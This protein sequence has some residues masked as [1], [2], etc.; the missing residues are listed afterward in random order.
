MHVDIDAFRRQFEKQHIG[1]V[2]F[3]MQHVAIGLADG[4][5]E[6]FVAHEAAVDKQILRVAPGARIRRQAGQTEQAQRAGCLVQRAGG[7]GEILAEHFQRPRLPV[8]DR[9]AP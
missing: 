2:A 7:F 8:G 4:V 9:E 1:R 3:V 6:Q 5:V